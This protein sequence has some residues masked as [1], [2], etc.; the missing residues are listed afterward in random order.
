VAT[1]QALA[2]IEHPPPPTSA[3]VSWAR[4]CLWIAVFL[5][6]IYTVERNAADLSGGA[7]TWL[8][9]VRGGGPLV[10]WALSHVLSPTVRRGFGAVEVYLGLFVVAALVS[11]TLPAN[12]A[13]QVTLFKALALLS[14][15]L[16]LGRLV[17]MYSSPEEVLRGLASST[18]VILGAAVIQ[19][20]A[21]RGD[22]YATSEGDELG[23]ARLNLIVP[24]ISAN[25]L[26]FYGVA[27]VTASMLGLGPRRIVSSVFLRLLTAAGFAA[28]V[29]LTRTRSAL[30]AA[31]IVFGLILLWLVV[32]RPVVAAISVL[33]GSMLGLV[34]VD[35]YSE[36]IGDYLARE[37]S[38]ESVNTLTGRTEIW[39]AAYDVWQS[40][41]W[42][43]LGYFAGHR[44]GIPGLNQQQSNIDNTWLE[45]L[46]D[47]GI[48]GTVPIVLFALLGLARLIR[49]RLV[50]VVK[51]WAATVVLFGLVISAINPSLQTPSAAQLLILLPIL[52]AMPSDSAR[53][54]DTARRP[55]HQH[56]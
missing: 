47:V 16:A 48:L 1:V 31:G 23:V 45:L 7:T 27:G 40:E 38:R 36:E 24:Q 30:I 33:T 8:D 49:A 25:P 42:F 17:R 29:A 35:R 50:G 21:F 20:I 43:G 10:L 12:P 51:L 4:R 39:A 53:S 46:V 3:G 14:A 32:R 2:S 19:F 9:I 54:P 55:Q 11:A 52:A 56:S 28:M 6:F 34:A 44:L 13:P 15:L 26:A 37:Q 18:Y 22:T 5:P 41:P